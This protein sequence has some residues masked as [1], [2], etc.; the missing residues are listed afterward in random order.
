MLIN[1]NEKEL[2]YNIGITE[3]KMKN[4]YKKECRQIGTHA[5]CWWEGKLVQP[6][7]KSVWKF[8]KNLK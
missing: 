5:H 4:I 3:I 1:I 8:F 7:W 6:L 2:Q